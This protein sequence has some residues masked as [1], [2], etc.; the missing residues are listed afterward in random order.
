MNDL[1]FSYKNIWFWILFIVFF[2]SGFVFFKFPFEFY[3]H[4]LFLILLTPLFIFKIGFPN[5]IF[6]LF[7]IPFLVGL[8][9]VALGN[10]LFFTFFKIIG[11]LFLVT[12]FFY[13]II[14]FYEFD[15]M[16]IFIIYCKGTWVLCLISIFQIVFY[17]FN[18]KA[19]YDFSWFLNKWGFV[20]GGI[21]GFRVN[22]I[23]SEP[24]YLATVLSPSVYLSIK[25]LVFKNKYIFNRFQS[26]IVIFI[27]IMT[28]SSVGYVGILIS[29]LLVTNTIRLRYF[30]I[31]L[32][33]TLITFSLSYTYVKDVKLRADAARGLWLDEN[34]NINNTNNS[35]FVLYN[36][37]HIAKENLSNYLFFGTGLGSHETAFKKFTL[38]KSLIQYDFEF[39][40]KDGNSLFVR[41][42]TETGLIGLGFILLLLVKGFIYKVDDDNK[43]LF[44][45]H[46]I[47]QSIFVLLILVLIRQGNYMLN[48][49][50]L[51]FLMYFYNYTQYIDKLN[52]IGPEN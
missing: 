31:G 14:H 22:S 37:L 28:T 7:F 27:S 6:K 36:N 9:H 23:L 39:N 29:F 46:L 52:K 49:L 4:Y 30:I 15:I 18:F 45:H 12:L 44:Y 48:G 41:L 50:P 17:Y 51:L 24:T 8:V 32:L 26:I 38:T 11:G 40:I 5:F 21:L 35:S 42:C 19:G 20:E 3:F 34:F 2:S 10:N 33:I 1:N 13:Y 16:T 43:D 25:N 47:S